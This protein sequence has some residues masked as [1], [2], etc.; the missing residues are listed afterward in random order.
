MRGFLQEVEQLGL[1]IFATE[2]DVRD[3]D[4]LA[5]ISARDR[6]VAEAYSRHLDVL[7]ENRAVEAVLTWGLYDGESW[8]RERQP[9]IDGRPVRPLPFDEGLHPQPAV[10]AMI[11]AFGKRHG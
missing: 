9:R 1:K 6:G 11:H 10:E 2:L 7:L 8:L 5:D 3:K 4:L